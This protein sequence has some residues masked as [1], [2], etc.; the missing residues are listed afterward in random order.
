MKYILE[1]MFIE[2]QSIAPDSLGHMEMNSN[3]SIKKEL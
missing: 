1:I 3:I 2:S